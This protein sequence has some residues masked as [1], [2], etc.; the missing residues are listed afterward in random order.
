MK[1]LRERA[2]LSQSALASKLGITA[3]AVSKW[4]Q[5]IAFPR[6]M[7]AEMLRLREVLKCSEKELVEAQRNW[8][9]TKSN[10]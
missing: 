8:E 1:Q 7:P 2:E 6:L 9:A 3:S 5:G 10:G 4:D